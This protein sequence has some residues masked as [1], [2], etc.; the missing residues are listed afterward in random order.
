MYM[1][2]A[3]INCFTNTNF[4]KLLKLIYVWRERTIESETKEI[5]VW[6]SEESNERMR[7]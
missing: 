4:F 2:H 1:L 3:E 7:T 5:K 6:R